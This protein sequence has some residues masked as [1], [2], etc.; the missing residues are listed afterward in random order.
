MRDPWTPG[1]SDGIGAAGGLHTYQLGARGAGPPAR[2]H[3]EAERALTAAPVRATLPRPGA[4]CGNALAW[5]R[6]IK[7]GTPVDRAQSLT[8]ADQIAAL[9]RAIGREIVIKRVSRQEWKAQAGPYVDGPVGDA[10][11]DYWESR[12]GRPAGLT[13]VVEELTGRPART[14]ASWAEEH[15]SAFI[16]GTR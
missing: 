10:L 13:P 6:P 4:F 5:A 16:D 7:A 2:S 11:L 12:D 14:F 3:V 8:F 15:R 9:S 1:G